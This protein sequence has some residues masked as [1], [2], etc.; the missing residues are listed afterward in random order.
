MQLILKQ[1]LITL[2]LL[3]QNSRIVQFH[4]T[5]KDLESLKG[6]YCIVGTSFM[7]YMYFP[8]MVP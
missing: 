5:N 8:H 6:F 1:V 4:F 2:V 7:G 3:F